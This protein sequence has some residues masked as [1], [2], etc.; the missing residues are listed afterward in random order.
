VKPTVVAFAG[1]MAS[2]KTSLSTAVAAQLGWPRVS[3][4]QY[5]RDQAARRGLEQGREALQELGASLIR[6]QGWEALCRSVLEQAPE[7]RPGANVV[8]DGVR[9][10][11][12]VTTLRRLVHPST[13]LLVCLVAKPGVTAERMRQRGV[14]DSAQREV[15]LSHSTE[16]EVT[17]GVAGMADVVLDAAQPQQVLLRTVLAHLR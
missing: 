10:V 7:W 17:S 3:F 8:V 15:L 11:D 4:G 2:G 6:E 16:I 9:H 13:L 14:A 5:V 12:A 1:Q